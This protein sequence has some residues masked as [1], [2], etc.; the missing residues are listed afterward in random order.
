VLK[1]VLFLGL[2]STVF[3]ELG[4]DA[5]SFAIGFSTLLLAIVIEAMRSGSSL[6]T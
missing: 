1:V 6:G 2:I 3:F 4:L 5:I